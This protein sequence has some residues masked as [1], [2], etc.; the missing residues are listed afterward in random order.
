MNNKFIRKNTSIAALSLAV[1][2]GLSACGNIVPVAVLSGEQLPTTLPMCHKV[3]IDAND[4][5]YNLE[6]EVKW[7]K[8]DIEDL[9]NS[10]N[11]DTKRN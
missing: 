1:I 5:I 8:K 10:T 3:F 4:R 11:H 9:T 7:L 6:L 2:V